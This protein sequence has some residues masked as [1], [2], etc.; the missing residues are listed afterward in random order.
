MCRWLA[1]SG[2]A[3]PLETVLFR[4]RHSL[5]DQSLHS[6]LGVTTTNGDGF[7]LGW[8]QHP[9]DIPY[10]YR[11]VHPAWNDRN[12]RELARAV[13]APMVVAHVRAA[14][15]TPV[16]ETNCHPF[17]HRR[18]L[19]A[20]NGLIRDFP[21]MRRDLVVAIDPGRFN[22]IEGSTDSE[23][24][25]CL[26][27]TF[28]LEHAPVPALERMAGFVEATG[29]AHGVREPLNMTVCASD[30]EQ[31]IAVRYSSE[32]QSRSLFHSTSFRHLHE[33]YPDDP[34]I[35]A[36]GD[37]AYLIVSE[38]LVSLPDAWAEVPE[39]TAIVVRGARIDYLPFTPRVD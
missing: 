39:A 23:V 14:T 18:W 9:H 34:R 4:A 27:M 11:S 20:H 13:S 24:M 16:Q 19:F 29:R 6:T 33:L 2:N 30:G 37:D 25:F 10:R 7:G 38:P 22:T 5:I 32:R 12:L 26:A 31:L 28:G 36:V 15:H 8:Y 3:V 35:A 1:Y 17:R 21:L